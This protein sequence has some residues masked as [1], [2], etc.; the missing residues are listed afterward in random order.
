MYYNIAGLQENIKK[1][2]FTIVRK[3]PSIN[4]KIT[5]ELEKVKDDFKKEADTRRKGIGYI[6]HLPNKSCSN[7]KIIEQVVKYLD[8]GML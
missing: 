5:S 2:F 4:N 1:N 7:E 6:T 8:L 3:I